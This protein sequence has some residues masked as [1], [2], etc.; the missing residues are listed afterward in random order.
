MINFHAVMVDETGCEFGAGIRA[1]TRQEAYEM[2]EENYPESR[3][4]QL[5]SPEDT[6]HREQA[7]YARVCA[8]YDEEYEYE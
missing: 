1:A 7:I 4:V 5:E 3:C 2:L 6:A 8:E